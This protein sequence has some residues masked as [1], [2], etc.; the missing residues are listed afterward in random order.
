MIEP[1]VKNNYK[2]RTTRA[3]LPVVLPELRGGEGGARRMLGP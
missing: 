2:I 1:E 3:L